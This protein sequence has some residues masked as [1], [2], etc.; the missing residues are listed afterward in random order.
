MQTELQFLGDLLTKPK[1]PL[2]VILGGGPKIGDKIEVIKNL[3]NVADQLI[4]GGG[5]SNPFLKHI[6]GHHLGG[7]DIPMPADT[8]DLQEIMEIAMQKNVKIH[9][10]L[11]A[12][13][14]QSLNPSA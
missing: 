14:A 8:K 13:C 10:P 3:L 1:R 6:Q 4:I 11:D 5:L 9:L 12:V 2:L 7:A